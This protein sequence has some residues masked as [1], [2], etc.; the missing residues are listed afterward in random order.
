MMIYYVFILCDHNSMTPLLPI[1]LTSNAI[2]RFINILRGKLLPDRN[3]EAALLDF[4][5]HITAS[6]GTCIA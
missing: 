1:G 6:F 4:V 5:L 2:F 3:M